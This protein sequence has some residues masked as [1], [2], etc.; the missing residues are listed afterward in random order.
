VRR[1][2]LTAALVLILAASPALA[3]DLGRWLPTLEMPSL[4]RSEAPEP[5][6]APPPPVAAPAESAGGVAT[7]SAP[8][9]NTPANVRPTPGN[10]ERTSSAG[11]PAPRESR[12]TRPRG[13]RGLLPGSLR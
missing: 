12:R 8:A 9:P 7:A 13:W 4:P 10:V 2:A 11:S 3:L 1:S 5:A 6:V